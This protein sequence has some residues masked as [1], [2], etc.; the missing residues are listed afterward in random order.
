[1]NI[2]LAACSDILVVRR[3]SLLSV[4]FTVKCIVYRRP[5]YPFIRAARSRKVSEAAD[6]GRA[7][8]A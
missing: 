2:R 7:D 5:P 1:M 4:Y 6:N 8:V 3:T